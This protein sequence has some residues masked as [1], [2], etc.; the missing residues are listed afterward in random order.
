MYRFQESVILTGKEMTIACIGFQE[1]VILTGKEMT[2][3]L[4]VN[5]STTCGVHIH[6]LGVSIQC[7]L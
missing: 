7:H 5:V 2:I 4:E 3:V 1:S 6:P